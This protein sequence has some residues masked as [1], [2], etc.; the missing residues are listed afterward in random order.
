MDF[1]IRLT[2]MNQSIICDTPESIMA[3]R[4]LAMRG[5]LKLETKGLRHSRGSVANSVRHMLNSRTKNKE[6]LLA[7]YESYLHTAG[8]LK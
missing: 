2:L 8:I 6:K 1:T 4:L 3:F 7:E 5:A